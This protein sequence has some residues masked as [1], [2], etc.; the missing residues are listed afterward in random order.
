MASKLIE[1]RFFYV[2]EELS[3]AIVYPSAII[4]NVYTSACAK[5][6]SNERDTTKIVI[7]IKCIYELCPT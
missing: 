2:H 7:A 1:L 5:E 3:T 6:K 4:H